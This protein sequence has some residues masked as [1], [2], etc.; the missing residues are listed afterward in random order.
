MEMVLQSLNTGSMFKSK[1]APSFWSQH[2]A[3]KMIL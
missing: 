1:M 3:M 2:F